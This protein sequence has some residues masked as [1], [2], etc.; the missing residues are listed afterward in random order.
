LVILGFAATVAAQDPPAVATNDHYLYVP[1]VVKAPGPR[2]ALQFDGSDDFAIIADK[3]DFD[4]NRTMTLEAWL[5]PLSIP[6]YDGWDKFI[7]LVVGADSVPPLGWDAGWALSQKVSFENRWD[8]VIFEAWDSPYLS[9]GTFGG[10]IQAGRWDHVA[11]TY[12]E[13]TEELRLYLNGELVM[14][15]SAKV[16]LLP[17]NHILIGMAKSSFHG[18]IDEVRVWN[19]VRTEAQIQDGMNRILRG[20]EP[21]LVGYWRLD[22]GSG[23]ALLDASLRGNDGCLGA[24]AAP[25]S[26]DPAWVLSDA[27]VE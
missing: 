16:D 19:V 18:L 9:S 15:A 25:D 10:P 3:G 23:Q 6:P 13:K 14:D 21:G 7:G 22:E 12:S 5:K 4:F 20:D 1:G 17:V 26:H 2:Y 24:T 8:E 27:P 11:G